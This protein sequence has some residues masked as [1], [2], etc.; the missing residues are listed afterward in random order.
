MGKP[1]VKGT[2]YNKVQYEKL[3]ELSARLRQAEADNNLR[4]IEYLNDYI[5]LINSL[6]KQS[7]KRRTR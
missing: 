2:I 4:E 1:K 6:A 5:K 7:I 3:I